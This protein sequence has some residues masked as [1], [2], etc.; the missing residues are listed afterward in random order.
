MVDTSN[1]STVRSHLD[2]LYVPGLT[3]L[4]RFDYLAYKSSALIVNACGFDSMPSEFGP[5]LASKAFR[6][7]FGDKASLG[8]SVSACK[9][10]SSVSGGT[11]DSILTMMDTPKDQIA[12]AFEDWSLSPGTVFLLSC[13]ISY[14]IW[15]VVSQ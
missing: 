7:A 6:A 4:C 13:K 2:I 1:D 15:C 12:A 9:V 14:L 5:Y 11:I 10:K 3:V 8:Q